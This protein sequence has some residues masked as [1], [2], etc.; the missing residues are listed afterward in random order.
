[1]QDKGLTDFTSF[2]G[3][4]QANDKTIKLTFL[5]RVDPAGEVV[6]DFGPIA[7]TNE[8]KFIVDSWYNTGAKIQYYSLSGRSTDGT[9][10]NSDNLYF[11]SLG[12][13]VIMSP[14]IT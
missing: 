2:T 11:N 7:L 9:E 10:F 8:T 13:S 4:L 6:F 14:E 12:H 1:M 5:V 3:H